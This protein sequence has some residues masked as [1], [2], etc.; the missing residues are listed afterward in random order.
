MSIDSM[1]GSLKVGKRADL[2][3][4]DP[5]EAMYFENARFEKQGLNCVLM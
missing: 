4:F 5:K 1:K 3:I 2:V